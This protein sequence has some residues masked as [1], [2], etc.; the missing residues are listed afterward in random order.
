LLIFVEESASGFSTRKP[1]ADCAH[2]VL[3]LKL[4]VEH[5][6]RRGENPT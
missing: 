3:E 1:Q 6:P 4:H 5:D 2:L